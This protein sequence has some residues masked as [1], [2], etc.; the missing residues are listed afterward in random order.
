[1]DPLQLAEK[2]IAEFHRDM[3]ALN[4]IRADHEPRVTEH[5]DDIIAIVKS[6]IEKKAAYAAD[7]MF[8]L[9]WRHLTNM[10]NSPAASLRT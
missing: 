1:M 10:A 9:P 7:E 8:F 2:F 3:D 5:I 4:V 6:L